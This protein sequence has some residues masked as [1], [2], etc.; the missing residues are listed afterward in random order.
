MGKKRQ[1]EYDIMRIIAC[2]GVIMI[3]AAVFDQVSLYAKTT[4]SYQWIYIWGVLSRWAV[5]AFVMLSGMM[6]LPA[7]DTV[8]VSRLLTH[9]VIRMMVIYVVW[10]A[11]YSAYNV[12]VL[13]IV[14]APTK[15][16]TFL[17]GCFSGELHMWYIPMIAGLYLISPILCTLVKKL[18]CRWTVFWLVALFTFSSVIPFLV[19]LDIKF[20][21]AIIASITEYADLQFLGGWT[22][23]FVLGYYI[24]QHVFSRRERCAVYLIALAALVYTLERTILYCMR[25][26]VA[27]GVQNYEYPNMY[28]VSVGVM[29]F[30]KDEVSR[31]HLPPRWEKGIAAISRLTFGIYLSHVLLL[32]I[33]YAAGLNLQIAH[34]ALSVPAVSL[35]VFAAGAMLSKLILSIPVVGKYIA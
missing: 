29:V 4:W 9:R 16:K 22:L 12:Y 26:G 34:T 28:A 18:E 20:V 17:D 21:S 33:A 10:S 30:F 35:V 14:Y 24:R 27:Y 11:V 5:P 6:I 31:I 25:N 23:Y 8:S 1:T 19:K 13:D 15:F 2:F 7:A 3:H 32:R